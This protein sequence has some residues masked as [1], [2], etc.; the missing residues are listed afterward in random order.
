VLENTVLI[1][2][3]TA[4]IPAQLPFVS[5]A[6]Q[7][8]DIGTL[9]RP[10]VVK[11]AT[12]CEGTYS[13]QD[14]KG[15]TS[16]YTV[17]SGTTGT[18]FFITPDGYIV[19]NAHIIQFSEEKCRENLLKVLVGEVR[20]RN[21][22]ETAKRIK[23]NSEQ[24]SFR[25]LRKVFLA[26]E[27]PGNDDG[28]DYDKESPQ[29]EDVD[30]VNK[31]KDVAVIKI[32]GIDTAPTIK[33]GKS[34]E[35]RPEG[36][37]RIIGY[38]GV[39]DISSKSA[40]KASVSPGSIAAIKEMDNDVKVLQIAGE[41]LPGNSGSP[42]FNDAG[43]VIGMI[44]FRMQDYE[45]GD[46]IPFAVTTNTILEY[47]RKSGALINQESTTGS[48]FRQGLQFYARGDYEGAKLS[49]DQVKQRFPQHSEIDEYIRNTQVRLTEARS[50]ERERFPFVW[51]GLTIA[52]F[53][54]LGSMYWLLKKKSNAV[55]Y[56]TPEPAST[57]MVNSRIASLFHR[58]STV[59]GSTH[60]L[61]L[62][63][64]QGH[65]KQFYLRKPEHRLGRDRQWADFYL[66]DEGWE[67][68]SR[69]HARLVREGESYR[70][71]DINSA[72]KLL[73][74]GQPIDSEG[75]LLQN[76]DELKIGHHP[77]AQVTLVYFSR[78]QS[79]LKASTPSS[80]TPLQ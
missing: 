23:G 76:R 39:A 29:G 38:P 57:R 9:M 53:A 51:S 63:N 35:V 8:K 28:R 59:I 16:D 14:A 60:R 19:T 18:G 72:N 20:Q 56:Q 79:R 66:P 71:Y 46:R 49:F 64:Q 77:S 48:L 70:I 73:I 6:D 33:F 34:E 65:P 25:A 45:T 43:E 62:S 80:H 55:S 11:I 37:V 5:R 78:L 13:Y 17:R 32:N 54:L 15:S 68:V 4:L 69:Q 52:G 31:G 61:E 7:P 40:L 21:S 42:V 75:Y 74:N 41:I 30:S 26:N 2:A 24:R 27:K 47:V 58:P 50:Q 10:T 22:S 44:A 12:G 3:I 67:V 36:T 1:L